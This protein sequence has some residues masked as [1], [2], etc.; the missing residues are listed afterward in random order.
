MKRRIS[1]MLDDYRDDSVE[2]SDPAPLSSERIK[3]ITMS[4]IT[5]KEKKGKR[6]AFRLLAAAAVVAMLTMTAFAVEEIFGAGDILRNVFGE[7]ISDQQ[8]EVVNKLGKVFEEQTQTSEGTTVT[9]VAAYGDA[10]MLHLYLKAEAPEGSVLPHG[11]SYVF[12]DYNAVDYSDPDHWGDLVPGEGA[13]YDSISRSIDIEPLPDEDPADNKK[14]FHVVIN[15]QS[16]TECKFNDGYSKYF[17][18]TGIYQQVSDVDGD[19]D[20]YVQ[21]APGNFS[22]DVGMVNEVETIE[23]DVAGLVY[24]G[25]K[26]RTWTHDSSCNE[27]CAEKLTGETDPESGLPIHSESWDYEVTVQSMT[28]SPLSADWKVKFTSSDENMSFGL[29][30]QVVLKDGTVVGNLIG[31]MGSA[32]GDNDSEGTTYFAQPI[33]LD[34]VDY[35]LIGDEEIGSTYKVYLPE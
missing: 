17:N 28:I 5:K 31:G 9:M 34:E 13:P 27:L 19:Q 3:E 12:V 29:S 6:I 4:K 2:F 33:D 35:V 7:K 16:G 23:L 10:Y 20:G 25:H 24:G 15:G 26:T 11:I 18:M 1:D 21:L 30:Y 22:F 8:V 14:D 32:W